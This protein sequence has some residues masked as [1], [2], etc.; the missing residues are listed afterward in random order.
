[1]RRH[2]APAFQTADALCG[3]DAEYRVVVWNTAAEQLFGVASTAAIGAH[4]YEVISGKDTQGRQICERGCLPMRLASR[5]QPVSAMPMDRTG[6][7]GEGQCLSCQTL[8]VGPHHGPGPVLFHIF[9]PNRDRVELQTLVRRLGELL[10]QPGNEGATEREAPPAS[11]SESQ[12]TPR[13]IEVLRHLKK[14]LG[15]RAIAARLGVSTSTIYTHVENVRNK[16][17]ARTR[18]QALA[19]AEQRGLL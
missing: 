17:Q 7:A 8:T 4:C 12:L 19:T 3:V 14:G 15:T 9:L 5:G 13:E 11:R 18:L 16:L 2:P 6:P 10:R 1:M